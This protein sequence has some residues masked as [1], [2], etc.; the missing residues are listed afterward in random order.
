MELVVQ[1][2][3]PLTISRLGLQEFGLHFCP[4]VLQLLLQETSVRIVFFFFV[5][6]VE[7]L[8]IGHREPGDK[9]GSRMV[10]SIGFHIETTCRS[11]FC[12]EPK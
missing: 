2:M 6:I 3:E 4:F 1:V 11:L 5:L 12:L 8:G 9:L 10:L 7:L